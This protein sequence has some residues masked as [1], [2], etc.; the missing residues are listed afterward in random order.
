LIH[1]S[2]FELSLLALILIGGLQNMSLSTQL[3]GQLELLSCLG[4]RVFESGVFLLP[5]VKSPLEALQAVS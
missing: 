5:L 2:L 4:E 3:L 1:L